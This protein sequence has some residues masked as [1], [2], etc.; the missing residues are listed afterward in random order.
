[1]TNSNDH[2]G[3]GIDQPDAKGLLEKFNEGVKSIL[4]KKPEPEPQTGMGAVVPSAD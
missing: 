1:M 2:A 4:S 3:S